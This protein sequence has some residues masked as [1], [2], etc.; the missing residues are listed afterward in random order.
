MLCRQDGFAASAAELERANAGFAQRFCL[1]ADDINQAEPCLPTSPPSLAEAVGDE[2]ES[3]TTAAAVAAIPP[4]SKGLREGLARTVV[5]KYLDPSTTEKQL[6]EMM[7]PVGD[8]QLC[9]IIRHK[10]SSTGEVVFVDKHAAMQAIATLNGSID[11]KEATGR[12]IV[13]CAVRDASDRTRHML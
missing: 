8:V 1:S 10:S 4:K 3:D 5:V 13:V 7:S 9:R 2:A 11:Y 6:Y 12:V